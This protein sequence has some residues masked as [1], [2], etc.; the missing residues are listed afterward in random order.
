MI[1]SMDMGGF[2]SLPGSRR[3]EITRWV[4]AEGLGNAVEVELL[5]EGS[6]RVT[7]ILPELGRDETGAWQTETSVRFP[8][9]P[10]PWL[11]WS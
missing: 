10:P 1:L 2:L 6:A 5:G 3:R 11:A 9:T 7:Q 4:L 8:R